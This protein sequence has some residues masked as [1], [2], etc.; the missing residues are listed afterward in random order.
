MCEG[1][2]RVKK[3]QVR[4]GQLGLEPQRFF[5]RFWGGEATEQIGAHWSYRSAQEI[6]EPMGLGAGAGCASNT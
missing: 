6:Q 4:R 1:T 5:H 2:G 3:A